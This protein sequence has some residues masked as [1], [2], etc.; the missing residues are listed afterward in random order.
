M[1]PQDLET[2]HAFVAC[3]KWKWLPGMAV[4]LHASTLAVYAGR[5]YGEADYEGKDV[6]PDLDDPVTRAALLVV[7]REAWDDA[8][9]AAVRH[10]WSSEQWCVLGG[11][12]H[13]GKFKRLHCRAFPSE[14]A[15]LKAALQAAP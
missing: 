14:L 15:A 12:E 2:A 9:L 13:G 8:G 7:V 1:S 11:K 4:I 5:H 10:G 3:E 6:V